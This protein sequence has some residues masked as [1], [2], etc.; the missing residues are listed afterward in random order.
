MVLNMALEVLVKI[1]EQEK[2]VKGIQIGMKERKLSLFTDDRNL[3]ME[4][5][6]N[7]QES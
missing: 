4:N 7:P 2:E 3:L 1:N 6:K 5:L